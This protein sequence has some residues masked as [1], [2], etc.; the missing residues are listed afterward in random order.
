MAPA[1]TY[2]VSWTGWFV[3]AQGYGRNWAQATSAG[4]AFF[5]FDSLRSWVGYQVSVL[6][7]HSGLSS[8][9]RY[10]SEPWQWPLLL[11][12]VAF[13]YVS[14]PAGSCGAAQCSEAIL[15]V[16][17]PVIWLGTLVAFVALIAWYVATRDWRAGAVLLAYAA[18]W[19][20]WFYYAFA[21]NRTMFLFYM[22]PLVPFMVLAIVLA[23]GLLIG[24]AEEGS[25]RRTLGA[26]L[27]GAFTL[28]AL[29]NFWWLHP[30]IS[31]EP[32]T[33]LQ[34]R[35]RMLFGSWV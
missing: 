10:Q 1:V 19:V 4:P 26:S 6:G 35:A 9:H 27:V 16:G 14:P 29:V 28:L 23:A 8:P 24:P 25:T 21:D 2:I 31:A 12:P 18:G 34:W 7:F 20:P 3:S 15:G 17:T 22:A 13:H 33:Y 32:V 5:V 11:R 30:V